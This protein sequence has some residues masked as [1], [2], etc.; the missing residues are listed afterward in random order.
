MVVDLLEEQMHDDMI[1]H[2]DRDV[3][4]EVEEVR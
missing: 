4:A 1:V 3:S 2:M